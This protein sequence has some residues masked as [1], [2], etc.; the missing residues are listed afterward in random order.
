MIG[1]GVPVGPAIVV[2]AAVYVWVLFKGRFIRCMFVYL[3]VI[4]RKKI[5]TLRA[6]HLVLFIPVV[7]GIKDTTLIKKTTFAVMVLIRC[8]PK[9]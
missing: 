4:V 1:A 6:K 5:K 9:Y 7:D 2:L 8:L 3:V